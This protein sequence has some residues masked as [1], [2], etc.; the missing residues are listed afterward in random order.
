MNY[1]LSNDAKGFPGC[2]TGPIA[3]VGFGGSWSMVISWLMG[4]FHNIIWAESP[5]KLAEKIRGAGPGTV[6]VP[7][8]DYGVRAVKSLKKK[9][10]A[11]RF[12]MLFWKSST[13]KERRAAIN[14]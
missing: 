4:V 5:E 10:P 3:A 7:N 9:W 11:A 13:D 12:V 1:I 14:A 6:V 8:N 2:P